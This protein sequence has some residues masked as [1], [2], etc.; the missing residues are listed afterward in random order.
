MIMLTYMHD[1]FDFFFFFFFPLDSGAMNG[2][3]LFY[4]F[5]FSRFLIRGVSMEQVLLSKFRL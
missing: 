3:K 1:H 4:M 5:L 2:C